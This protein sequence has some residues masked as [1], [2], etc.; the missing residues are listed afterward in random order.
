MTVRVNL[1]PYFP[2]PR[3]TGS[4]IYLN[5]NLSEEEECLRA[6]T[7]T[8]HVSR[9]G[10]QKRQPPGLPLSSCGPKVRSTPCSWLL[11]VQILEPT[12]RPRL[13]FPHCRGYQRG[14]IATFY[15]LYNAFCPAVKL[16]GS[17]TWS[18]DTSRLSEQHGCVLMA[19]PRPGN[20][21]LGEKQTVASL[22]SIFCWLWLLACQGDLCRRKQ[23]GSVS[24]RGLCLLSVCKSHPHPTTF[25]LLSATHFPPPVLD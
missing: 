15:G 12:T 23:I 7:D 5:H 1:N 10:N 3:S 21:T 25:L 9:S 2:N 14:L 4:K 22:E 16:L 11:R 19:V 13:F 24:C 18:G 6:A 20:D 17:C 8:R